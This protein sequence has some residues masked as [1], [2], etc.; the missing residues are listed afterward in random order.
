MAPVGW[1]YKI[2]KY[3]T[4]MYKKTPVFIA[5][6]LG[7]LL[8]GIS[9]ITL[10]S[11]TPHLKTKFMLD[12]IAAGTL[13]SILPVGILTG[14]LLFGPVCDRYGYKLLLILACIGMFA[15]FEGIA[16]ANTLGVLKICV[17]IFG[18][19]GG[20]INGATNA[21]VADISDEKKGANLSLL[22]VF[23]GIG[24]LGMPLILG[25]LSH[26]FQP[27][28]IVAVVGW[29]TLV[30][31]LFYV[32]IQFP[33]PKLPT[34]SAT[35][36]WS[37][38]FKPLLLLIAF[39]L[40]C[41]SSLEAIIN[42]WATTYLITKSVMNE[43]HALY[44][45]SL[46]IVGMILM[47]LL[48]GSVFR[49]VPQIKMMWACL[50]LLPVGIF[51]MQMGS[52]KTLVIA[53]LILSGAGLAGGFPIMLGFVG[54]RFT[55]LSGTAFS[56]VFVI[57]LIG[58]MLINYVMGFIV[59]KYGVEHLTTVSYAEI[60]IMISLFIFISKKLNQ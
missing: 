41:Q 13:F 12:G 39:F 1:L 34:N 2:K 20:I 29:V 48:T 10:G 7:M 52:S 3:L 54:E 24:A 27:F 8:F 45:L 35:V 53:G 17:F 36:K 5:A 4:P 37:S 43:S 32:F 22:G 11:V 28:E 47:R 42:N 9:L 19:G 57:A 14:S 16:Y 49:S 58:N 15:G 18:F 33:P 59:H 25:L 38:L 30:V 23:F 31:A 51:L 46:H 56:F 55:A 60:V 40:F 6:F 44:A 21:V 50:I 26:K